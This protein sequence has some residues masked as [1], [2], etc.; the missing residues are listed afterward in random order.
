MRGLDSSIGT[1][2]RCRQTWLPVVITSA[3]AARSLSASLAVRPTPSAAFSPLTTQ[4]SIP[5][6][7]LSSG[8]RSV[9]AR[10]PGGPKTSPMKRIFSWPDLGARERG[11]R[12]HLEVHV[13]A[14]VL[15]VA[16]EPG[17]LHLR[18]VDDAADLRLPGRDGRADRQRRV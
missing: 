5:S 3:P 10:L 1:R 13:L 6:S 2:S 16:G 4:K 11:G 17:P 18:E 14:L 8:S 15:G 7:C 9:T 12:M